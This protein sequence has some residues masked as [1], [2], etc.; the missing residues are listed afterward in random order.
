MKKLILLVVLGMLI[1]S[2]TYAQEEK[3][4]TETKPLTNEQINAF[5]KAM[6]I[7]NKNIF[8]VDTDNGVM[9]FTKG[10]TKTELKAN[11]FNKMFLTIRLFFSIQDKDLREGV[12]RGLLNEYSDSCVIPQAEGDPR[13]ISDS[14]PDVA[15][16]L[17]HY[18]SRLWLR[19]YSCDDQ[20]I[21]YVDKMCNNGCNNGRCIKEE[22]NIKPERA[23]LAMITF[24][25]KG[26]NEPGR[27]LNEKIGSIGLELS[28]PQVVHF[29]KNQEEENYFSNP[30]FPK[31]LNM[32]FLVLTLKEISLERKSIVLDVDITSEPKLIEDE[33]EIF[34]YPDTPKIIGNYKLTSGIK[35]TEGD[36]IP[37]IVEYLGKM[38]KI[39]T[40][41]PNK[42]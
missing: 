6:D 2:F 37:A 7:Y 24:S 41:K 26:E 28:I 30:N 34:L 22:E 11:T 18:G 39:D 27:I 4:I 33:K 15:T 3:K 5:N 16:V 8:C 19:E 40:S 1:L 36:I 42:P 14:P 31:P 21:R 29:I 10:T 25:N 12:K 32:E 17:Q 38:D 9:E 35:D 23:V 13:F 20:K